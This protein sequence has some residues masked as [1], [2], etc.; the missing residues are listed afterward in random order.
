MNLAT[1]RSRVSNATGLTN[2]GSEQAL[3][4]GW[5]NE[6]VEQFLVETKLPKQEATLSLTANRGD[7]S[8]DSRILSFEDIYFVPAN[9]SQSYLLTPVDSR[10]IRR[11]R[12]SQAAADLNTSLYALEG[13]NLLM[14]Y[15]SPVSNTD[16][17][18]IIYVA[19]ASS[20]LAATADDPSATG[21]GRIPTEWHPVLEAYAKWKASEYNDSPRWEAWKQEWEMGLVK[22][23]IK[24]STKGGTRLPTATFGR[25]RRAPLTPGTD[26][27]R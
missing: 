6:A 18:H 2:S 25:P 12:L 19:R 11:R 3:I 16:A 26:L 17:V 24:T 1:M 10:E 8:L 23:K 22:S 9:G 20:A 13:A 5:L 7:Y 4:D 21:Y 15:P 27:G 14:L